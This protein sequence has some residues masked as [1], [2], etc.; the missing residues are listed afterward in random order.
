MLPDPLPLINRLHPVLASDQAVEQ[1]RWYFGIG[2][3]PGAASFTGRRFEHLAGGGDRPE[4]ANAVTADDL[5][6]VQT[7]SVT[8][9]AE[10]A[11][12]LLEGRLG[13]QLSDLLYEI[14][15]RVDMAEADAADLAPGSPTD[16][17]WRLLTDQPGIGWVTAGKLLARK[18][19]RFLPVYDQ[20]VRCVL[21][22]P[23]SF[24]LDL[25]AALRADDRALHHELVA[26]RRS[27]RIPAA[28]AARLRTAA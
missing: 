5:I 19:P 8:I 16:A 6:A 11:L 18:R 3:P 12:D 24:W 25:H 10:A 7:L 13:A 1:L 2:Q 9:P 15:N 4:A 28:G 17:A 27:A 26:L 22:R 20:V 14:P 21:G 23:A